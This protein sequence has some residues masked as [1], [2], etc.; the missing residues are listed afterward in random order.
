[1]GYG[2]G[3]EE[4][5]IV[6]A[7]DTS[8]GDHLKSDLEKGGARS[9]FKFQVGEGY[10]RRLFASSCEVGGLEFQLQGLEF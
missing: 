8:L 9:F 1:M 7:G 4:T 3:G 2:W 6:S 5:L 10:L